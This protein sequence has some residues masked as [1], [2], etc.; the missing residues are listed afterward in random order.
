MTGALPDCQSEQ[1]HAP[2][3]IISIR[4]V[5]IHLAGCG[6]AEPLKM[7]LTQRFRIPP[8][9][10]PLEAIATLSRSAS[11]ALRVGPVQGEQFENEPLEGPWLL[12]RAGR[13][14]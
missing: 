3:L 2:H 5:T 7:E 8:P 12:T 4:S 11:N 6:W 1:L 13:A 10:R 14:L 9:E